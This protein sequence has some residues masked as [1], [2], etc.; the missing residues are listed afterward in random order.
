MKS[1]CFKLLFSWEALSQKQE[2]EVRYRKGN[3]EMTSMGQYVRKVSMKVNR[4]EEVMSSSY[5]NFRTDGIRNST[6]D[7]MVELLKKEKHITAQT[8]GRGRSVSNVAVILILADIYLVEH[9]SLIAV[10]RTAGD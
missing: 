3:L 2:N 10:Q 6:F 8:C 5:P 1:F 9:A 4:R 7:G